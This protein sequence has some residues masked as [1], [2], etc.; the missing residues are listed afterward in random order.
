MVDPVSSDVATLAGSGL[1]SQALGPANIAMLP[2]VHGIAISPN[3]IISSSDNNNV[4]RQT[5]CPPGVFVTPSPTPTASFLSSPSQSPS[6]SASPTPSRGAGGASGPFACTVQRLSG[7]SNGTSGY[8]DGSSTTALFKAPTGL[9]LGVGSAVL[10]VCD[11]GNHVIRTVSVP[12]GVVGTLAGAAGLPGAVNGIGFNARFNSPYALALLSTP[13]AQLLIRCVAVACA[14]GRC[15]MRMEGWA[16]ALVPH[17]H[18]R[19]AAELC[20]PLGGES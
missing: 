18:I 13:V 2:N 10:F 15:S 4:V 16:C 1:T 6:Q 3:G 5:F 8:A 9:A 7:S 11:G 20:A 14:H 19:A 12:A 17:V